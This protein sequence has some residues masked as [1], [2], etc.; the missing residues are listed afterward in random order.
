MFTGAFP[1]RTVNFGVLGNGGSASLNGSDTSGTVSI[2]TGNN[3]T[4]GCFI[5]VVFNIPFAT[6]PNI[7]LG[8]INIGAGTIEHNVVLNTNASGVFTGFKICTA[9]VPMANQAFGFSYFI[10]GAPN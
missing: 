1:G 7:V 3:P 5:S 6:P 2:N 10:T 4:I 9:N 8:P